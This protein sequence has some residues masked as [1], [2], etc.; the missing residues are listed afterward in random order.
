MRL[1]EDE[2]KFIGYLARRGGSA[3]LYEIRR[4]LGIPHTSAWRMT[5]RLQEMGLIKAI[6]VRIG[7]R[8]LLKILLRKKGGKSSSE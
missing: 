3:Y 2:R 5:K 1:N 6:K 7:G 4:T 8:E